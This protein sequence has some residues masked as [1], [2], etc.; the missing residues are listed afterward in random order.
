MPGCDRV[1]CGVVPFK[2]SELLS[3]SAN[4]LLEH[5]G[6]NRVTPTEIV[7]ASLNRIEMLDRKG[8][9]L[10]AVI[11]RVEDPESCLPATSG[12][13]LFGLPVL[14]K[15]N[16]D[17]TAFAT[18][19]GSL[20]LAG[21]PA[22]QNAGIVDAL[23][24]LGAM[25]LGK[26]NL[27]EWSN[28]RGTHSSSG[29]SAV[30]GQ[31]RN[32][33]ALDRSPGGSSAGSAVAVAA[34]YVPVSF[35]TETDG[36]ILCPAALNGV[37]GFKPTLGV[38][39][40]SGVI[41]IAHSQ[42]TVGIFA[43]SVDDIELVYSSL[44]RSL[45]KG[46][47]FGGDFGRS[48]RQDFE[49]VANLRFGVPR[50]GFFGYSPKTDAVF[51]A[52]LSQLRGAGVK[53]VD[54]VDHLADCDFALDEADELT[55][56]HWEMYQDL[57]SYLAQRGVEGAKSLE[58]LVI[59]NKVNAHHELAL[60]GQE[61]FEAAIRIS[62]ELEKSYHLARC[63]NLQRAEIAI[64][65]ALTLGQVD[66]LCVPTMGPSWLIDHVNGDAI[67]GSG[68]SVAAVAG[69]A[70]ISIPIGETHGL[71]LGMTIFGGP[72]CDATLLAAAKFFEDVFSVSLV[73]RFAP[74][75]LV[76]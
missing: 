3:C 28:M 57:G 71:P 39:P 67:G 53:I 56:L 19:G 55:V 72:N 49:Q 69:V 45:G 42:D 75:V 70:S 51:E 44:V 20:A 11:T 25:V 21:K 43:R 52:A 16:I 61:H 30:G 34:G 40:T 48:Y 22:N 58:D 64:L 33:F 68:Y 4:S 27:S 65:K 10:G 36:S 23:C 7:S 37:V 24:G 74:T 73:P 1:I 2:S 35:G 9:N 12:G 46:Q 54:N 62:K 60:F 5:L 18:T 26:T 63:N 29:W 17:T 47:L 8:P 15:D 6:A 13:A 50:H 38:L 14:L 31:C 66:L 59:F 76:T 41:P 32:P